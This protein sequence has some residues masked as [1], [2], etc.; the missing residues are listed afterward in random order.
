M[1]L[2]FLPAGRQ[3]P[4]IPRYLGMTQK[5]SLSNFL[6]TSV[7]DEYKLSIVMNKFQS[8]KVRKGKLM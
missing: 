7:K 8:I 1:G 6:L 5:Y 2:A 4:E 3:A